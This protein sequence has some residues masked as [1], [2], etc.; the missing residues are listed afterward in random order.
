VTSAS[1]TGRKGGSRD[2]RLFHPQE[3]G[4]LTE[5]TAQS[6]QTAA[7][8]GSVKRGRQKQANETGHA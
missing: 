5:K 4:G 2:T 6:G 1:A 8:Q 7:I 3:N